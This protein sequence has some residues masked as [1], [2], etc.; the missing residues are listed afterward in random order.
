MRGAENLEITVIES[1]DPRDI[2]TFRLR[3]D[4]SISEIELC[5]LVVCHDLQHTPHI[6]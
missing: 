3:H 5:A 2:E 6:I 1:S 4:G